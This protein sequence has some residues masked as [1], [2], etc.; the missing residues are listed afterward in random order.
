MGSGYGIDRAGGHELTEP[1]IAQA[2]SR[3]FNGLGGFSRGWMGGG[4]RSGVDVRFVEGQAEFFR[5]RTGEVQVGVGFGSA[6]AVV[7]MGR[8]EDKAQFPDLLGQSAQQRHR[9]GAAGEAHGQAQP[10]FEQ[11]GVER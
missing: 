4:F 11:G 9:V 10:R 7:E 2:A 6:Q 1:G 3:F 8:M 5:Q